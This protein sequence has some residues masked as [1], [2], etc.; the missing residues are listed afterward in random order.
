MAFSPFP[1]FKVAPRYSKETTE[2]EIS[3]QEKK[4]ELDI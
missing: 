3:S 1:M 2:L 4:K